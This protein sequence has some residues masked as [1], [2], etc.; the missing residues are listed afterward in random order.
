MSP[1]IITHVPVSQVVGPDGSITVE[2]EPREAPLVLEHHD[3]Y[4]ARMWTSVREQRN[5]LL[6]QSDWVVS[7]ASETG[8]PVPA[9]WLAYRQA[10]RDITKQSNPFFLV[11]PS[12]PK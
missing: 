1:N 11:W 6:E 7:R 2:W 4:H 5:R 3:V 12:E 10:L 9:E 8:T